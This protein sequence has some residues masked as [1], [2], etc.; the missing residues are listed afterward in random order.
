MRDFRKLKVWQKAHQLTLGTYKAT[1]AFPKIE[2]YGITTKSGVLLYLS[3]PT[4]RKVA[5]ETEMLSL[6][7]SFKLLWGQ[8]VS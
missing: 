2:I 6:P 5:A 4:L 8:Q 3:P 1:A 7:V